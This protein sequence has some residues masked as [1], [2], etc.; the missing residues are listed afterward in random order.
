MRA[1]WRPSP[2]GRGCARRPHAVEHRGG[3][4]RPRPLG[5]RQPP[6]LM[7]SM[8]RPDRPRSAL[9]GGRWDV[10]RRHCSRRRQDIDNVGMRTQ[11]RWS[12]DPRTA[13]RV[14]RHDT[15]GHDTGPR[16]IS[17]TLSLIGVAGAV[18]DNGTAGAPTPGGS[19]CSALKM[20]RVGRG[21]AR[22]QR[23]KSPGSTLSR[24]E[25]VGFVARNPA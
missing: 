21:K 5:V 18:R 10:G 8:G 20:G 14:S 13:L 11:P 25:R 6:V 24:R 15:S 4:P 3:N 2:A 12:E 1:S 22:T 16:R 17:L 7:Q 19:L 9:P 23:V